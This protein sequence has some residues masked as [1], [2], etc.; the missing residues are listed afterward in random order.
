MAAVAD[1]VVA[2]LLPNYA[3]P[4]KE[5]KFRPNAKL[6]TN[7]RFRFTT[8]AEKVDAFRDH[9]KLLVDTE[10]LDSDNPAAP[11]TQPYIESA[12][13]KGLKRGWYDSKNLKGPAPHDPGRT[14]EQS[15]DAT[16]SSA[17][18]VR[19]LELL[20]TR[21]YNNL[22]GMTD[23]MGQ[24]L[25]QV[26]VEGMANG[27]AP[28]AVA[29]DMVDRIEGMTRGRAATI[30]RTEIIHAH[31]EGQLDAFDSAGVM[32][33]VVMAEWS[34]AG[35]SKVCS[36]CASLEGVVMT[37]KEARGLLP[38]HPNCRCAWL[39]AAVGE[40]Q[41]G[42][43]W[44]NAAREEA[45]RTSVGWET[46]N[47][48]DAGLAKSKWV[49]ADLGRLQ[50]I[51]ELKPE[52]SIRQEIADAKAA[53]DAKKKKVDDAAAKKAA[54][55]AALLK[56]QRGT[57]IGYFKKA[58]LDVGEDDYGPDG[59]LTPEAIARILTGPDGRLMVRPEDL[60]TLNNLTGTPGQQAQ[61]LLKLRAAAVKATPPPTAPPAPGLAFDTFRKNPWI[62][63]AEL[64]LPRGALA[65]GV[66]GLTQSEAAALRAYTSNMAYKLNDQLRKGTLTT[67]A[68]QVLEQIDSALAKV[69][70]KTGTFYRG[71]SQAFRA[72]L[73]DLPVGGVY[74]DRGYGS[75]TD[76]ME[77]A[78]THGKGLIEFVGTLPSVGHTSAVQGEK[79]FMMPR[80]TMLTKVG[81]Y[82]NDGVTV[83]QVKLTQVAADTV[84]PH[85]VQRFSADPTRHD[86]IL[87]VLDNHP[88]L[89]ELHNMT[90]ALAKDGEA[91]IAQE[92]EQYRKEWEQL[93]FKA[94]EMI[95]ENADDL[96][97]QGELYKQGDAAWDN[98]QKAQQRLT[99]FK[100]DVT[101]LVHDELSAA[102]NGAPAAFDVFVEP[103]DKVDK[104]VLEK[105]KKA[106]EFLGK[107]TAERPQ[108]K[109][110]FLSLPQG[111]D[112]SMPLPKYFNKPLPDGVVLAVKQGPDGGRAYHR[113]DRTGGHIMVSASTNLT[114]HAHE[115]GHAIENQFEMDS[116][117][118]FP[119]VRARV[120]AAGTKDTPLAEVFP[121]YGYR[122]DEIGNEDKF[123]EAFD[124]D[125][126]RAYYA[127]KTYADQSTEIISLGVER[128]LNDPVKF[129]QKDPQYFKFIVGVLGGH[130]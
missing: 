18:S 6:T 123:L 60:D 30:A 114:T 91:A 89:N 117:A 94:V 48:T 20:G 32:D 99:D 44:D 55:A 40:D 102:L 54:Q 11:W 95:P 85:R 116:T 38:R 61:R 68:S 115:V 82:E 16:F 105:N 10:L 83:V 120:A 96:K 106:V 42:Q 88:K 34:T 103:G 104:A 93:N 19:K 49:G 121:G 130:L 53:K 35:D 100:Y 76:S 31:A 111:Y 98:M 58:G 109:R 63:D 7:E 107:V 50:S 129:A 66:E 28:A 1:G 72:D 86:Y 122:P 65:E 57:A 3:A 84:G 110:Y 17:E 113:G 8:D 25:N 70:K 4:P 90:L 52:K 2:F 41:T 119:F 124:G 39:P 33:I 125:R 64:Q 9:L 51:A 80:G 67:G 81:Q 126:N 46:N 22:K 45:V 15:L 127:G 24:Q 118:S 12:Y 36:K 101:T 71:V 37:P 62:Q 69:P 97:R 23:A 87:D 5:L 74:Y 13:K 78:R 128:L 56:K 112:V 79:E 14:I 27:E 59:K 47:E 75:F 43:K 77:G 29:R 21:A 92:I 73:E 26:M 108:P